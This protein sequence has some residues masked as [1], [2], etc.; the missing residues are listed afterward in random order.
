M[1]EPYLAL[2]VE[3]AE[4]AK[5][6]NVVGCASG[7]AALHLALEALCLPQGSEVITSDYN[8]IAVPRAITMAGLTPV[9]VD[10]GDDLLID[11]EIVYK[12]I[13]HRT[14]AILVTHVYGRAVDMRNFLPNHVPII[15]DLAEAHG[16]NPDPKTTAAC[17]S[18]FRNKIIAGEEGG[19]V[20]FRDAGHA[21]RARELRCLGFTSAHDFVHTPRGHNYRMSNA[22]ARLILAS[23]EGVEDSLRQRR[24]IEGWYEAHCPDEWKMPARTVVWCYDVR[25]PGMS[26][27]IQTT[28]VRTLNSQGVRARHSFW[29]MSLQ[30]E[31]RHCRVIGNGVA[32]KMAEEVFYL[33]VE[34]GTTTEETVAATFKTIKTTLGY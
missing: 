17:W 13:S 21:A 5:V 19:A 22:H 29:P 10:C 1:L 30:E 27:E 15:E 28:V 9:F 33:P 23:L 6:R 20:A 32:R 18:F 8:M 25:V 26:R 34:P 7:S 11:A 12:A 24:T 14:E 3:F 4:W 2:E 31:Y 16:V